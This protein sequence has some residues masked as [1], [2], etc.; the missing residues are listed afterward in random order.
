MNDHQAAIGLSALGN[1]TR[2][3]LFRL[4]VK[5]GPDGLTVG[6]IQRHLDVPAS[7]L[8]HHIARLAQ[9]GL[10]EQRKDGREVI[11]TAGY[12]Q[13]TDLVA[14]VMRECCEG[15]PIELGNMPGSVEMATAG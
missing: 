11:C 8:A 14:Y 15:L 7:T 10:I 6:R 13:M 1:E 2:L 12:R 5:A 3:H 4:L 9:A